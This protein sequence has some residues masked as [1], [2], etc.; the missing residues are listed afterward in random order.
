MNLLKWS[1]KGRDDGM[2]KVRIGD[3]LARLNDMMSAYETMTGQLLSET[4]DETLLEAVL[5]NLWAKMDRDL[6]NEFDV[7][8]ELS[9][10]RRYIYAIYAV[11]GELR[12]ATSD[13]P[14]KK[15][16]EAGPAQYAL[17]AEA[18]EAVGASG[19]AALLR[20]G[21]TDAYF[22]KFDEEDVMARMVQYIRE[23]A[24]AFCD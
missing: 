6:E 11:T 13:K 7:M 8:A 5:S 22:M 10:E 12:Q 17:C 9:P 24:E 1:K 18:L 14:P 4:P 3:R 2:H 20:Q 15:M 19:S 21:E 23:H 16:K